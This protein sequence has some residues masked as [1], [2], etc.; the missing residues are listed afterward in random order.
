MNPGY[1]GIYLPIVT[2]FLNGEVDYKSYE[3]IVEHYIG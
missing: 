3:K 1:T 2:P